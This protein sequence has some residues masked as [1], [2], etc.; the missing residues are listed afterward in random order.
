MK[1]T[2]LLS[3][4]VFGTLTISGIGI[5]QD[6]KK[7]IETNASSYVVRNVPTT[8]DLND[9]T[10]SNIR[11]YYSSLNAL[12]MN[13]RQGTNLLK[14]L[15]PILKNNQKYFSYGSGATTKVWQAYEIVDRDWNL[16]PAS[17][18]TGYNPSTNIITG[19]VYG[20]SN[21]EVGTNPYVHAL[22]VNRNIT[23]ETKAWGNHNQDQW[24][25]NQEHIWAKSCGFE[26]KSHGAGARGDLMHLWAGNGKVNG[27]YHSNYY[28][29]FVD[30]TQTY[31]DAKDY[32]STLSGNLYGKSKT[33]GGGN[34]VFEPQDSDKGDIARA[35][36]YMAARYNYY[37]GVDSD[38]IDSG[39]PNL[40]LTNDLN[41]SGPSSKS[42]TSTETNPGQMG[43]LQ[44]LLEWNRLDPPDQWEIHRNNLLYT[45]FT[46]NRNPF[47]DYPEW[48]EYIWGKSVDGNYSSTVTGYATPT[49]D[50]INQFKGDEPSSSYTWN[51][52]TDT[53]EKPTSS[54]LVTWNSSYATM[55]WTKETGTTAVNNYLGGDANK[56]TSSRIY[57]NNK[58][59]ITPSSSYKIDS[60]VFTATTESFATALG[61]STWSN[62]SASISSKVVTVTP[63]N[64]NLSFSA[65]LS[66]TSGLT[67]AVVNYSSKP[68][69]VLTSISL[70]T[71]QVKTNYSLNEAFDSSGLIVTANYDDSTSEIV[72]PDDIST[73]DM[74]TIGSK[75][76][77][78]TYK[79]KT[80]TY[81]ITVNKNVTSITA[82]VN[83]SFYVGDSIKKSDI[84]VLDNYGSEISS[85]TFS[86][87]NYQ[88]VYSDAASGGSATEKTFVNSIYC[89]EY[90]LHCNLTVSVSRKAH[91]TS[92]IISDS[93]TYST[94]G[95]SGTIYKSWDN[96]IGNSGTVYS[97][98]SAGGNTSI[99]IRSTSPSG[100]VAS[101]SCVAKS[102]N[103]TWNSNTADGR[104]L[105]V[106]GNNVPYN[107][108]SDLY[109]SKTQGSLIGTIVKG[110]STSLSITS[111]YSYIGIR[112]N[113]GAEY[114]DEIVINWE[115]G[116]NTANNV[117]N[118]IM[119]TDTNNQ[120]VSKYPLAKSY[121]LNLP[122]TEK[123][124]FMT[125]T[126]YV[127]SCA[128]NRFIDW[129]KHNGE[130]INANY[131]IS[132]INNSSITSLDDNLSNLITI[133]LLLITIGCCGTYLVF[134]KKRNKE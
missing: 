64:K 41:W 48:A 10:E 69:K 71:L 46:N 109:D 16:S 117:A 106:Y 77:T 124:I 118:Y 70:D 116:V 21:T 88:F 99:Q 38:G 86:D 22:Y 76:V 57:T 43:I 59:T 92:S 121:Y 79:N 74:S 113:G 73:P 34:T 108:S 23:N 62:A 12:S 90:N 128:R 96:I 35:I 112:S 63:T 80:A 60:V 105:N 97:G 15:K 25:I 14:N 126:D 28:Y 55:Q 47:I 68:E 130:I 24:G 49:T 30:K 52:T 9:T 53:Y 61:N 58:L 4:F 134:K 125:S 127:I 31:H 93:I 36:F 3:I 51:L 11:N 1:S 42:Y 32:A 13:E 91:E 78:V 39:N 82:S 110:T 20:S 83:K 129:A 98:Q 45:N 72:T 89:S 107:S 17:K 95:I 114:L 119:Y 54:T 2:K 65:I 37:S 7:E 104:T 122:E 26:D 85:F 100:I 75:T 29:G 66:D 81:S 56:R 101:S 132:N 27:T 6:T 33:K 84:T 87:N 94:I 44:D 103:I 18:I 5:L 120:C 50:L 19:Y 111:K 123:T 8:I 40:E 102:I 115:K 131:S 67:S 133:H